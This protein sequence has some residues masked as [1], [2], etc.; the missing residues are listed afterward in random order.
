LIKKGLKN[1]LAAVDT[2][3]QRHFVLHIISLGR[4]VNV[5]QKENVVTDTQTRS[6]NG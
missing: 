4:K 2:I 6:R 3:S 5:R 1:A